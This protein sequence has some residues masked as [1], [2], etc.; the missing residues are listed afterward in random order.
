MAQQ[1]LILP[2]GF[3]PFLF[4]ASCFVAY[5]SFN[6][7]TFAGRSSPPAVFSISA[8]SAFAALKPTPLIS[9][10]ALASTIFA[11]IFFA[12]D[13]IHGHCGYQVLESFDLHWGGWRNLGE[14]QY[15]KE[16]V[17]PSQAFYLLWVIA[18]CWLVAVSYDIYQ[19]QTR[20]GVQMKGGEDKALRQEYD[21]YDLP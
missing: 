21:N 1:L 15:Y 20:R 5:L 3:R 10:A 16:C 2:E 8:F 17:L 7:E 19:L 14:L 11:P 13:Y 9:T 12:V 18:S 6:D 4:C